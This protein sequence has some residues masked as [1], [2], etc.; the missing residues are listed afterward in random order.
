MEHPLQAGVIE[1]AEFE[2]G[3]SPGARA[4]VDKDGEDC[5]VPQADDRGNIERVEQ[6]PRLVDGYLRR[7]AF[8]AVYASSRTES[9]GLGAMAWRVTMPSKKCR[10]AEKC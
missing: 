6:L 3:D 9:A 10:S 4:G 8:D 2:L 7:L 5:S 1:V